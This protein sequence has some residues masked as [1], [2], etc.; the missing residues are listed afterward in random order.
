MEEGAKKEKK[1]YEGPTYPI[2]CA[3]VHWLLFR[4]TY[5]LECLNFYN[6]VT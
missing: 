4:R 2:D 3:S 5:F 6:V 1:K